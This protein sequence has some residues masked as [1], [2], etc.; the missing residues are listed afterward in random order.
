MNLPTVPPANVEAEQSVLGTLTTFYTP[1]AV[2]VVQATGLKWSDF[3]YRQHRVVYRAV[4][5]LHAKGDEVDAITVRH[6]MDF[7]QVS[8]AQTGALLDLLALSARPGAL[9]EHARIVAEDGR[10]RRWLTAALVAMEAAQARDET[11]FWAAVARIRE[12]ALPG[13]LRLVEA[14]SEQGEAA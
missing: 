11:E 14:P 5:K 6:L 7:H 1:A 4:L 10:W 13:E 9:R 12:D 2:V 8:D 3:S